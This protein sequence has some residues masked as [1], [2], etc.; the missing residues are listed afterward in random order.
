MQTQPISQ[1]FAIFGARDPKSL[2]DAVEQAFANRCHKVAE[3]QWLV[4]AN[5]TQ[6]AEIYKRLTQNGPLSCVIVWAFDYY[7]WHDKAIWDWIE[8]SKRGE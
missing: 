3:G 1:V 2:D 7:G 6:P 5:T 4:S 8:A